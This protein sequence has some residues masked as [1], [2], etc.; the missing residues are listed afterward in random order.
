MDRLQIIQITETNA[1]NTYLMYIILAIAGYIIIKNYSNIYFKMTPNVPRFTLDVTYF[2][3]NAQNTEK[4]LQDYIRKITSKIVKEK[5]APVNDKLDNRNLLMKDLNDSVVKLDTKLK[6]QSEKKIFD[7][8]H[9]YLAMN[10][11]VTLLS[12]TL[13]Q[14]NNIQQ[15]NIEAVDKIYETYSIAM[16]EYLKKL[17]HVLTVINYQ[18]NITY[19]K[20][21]MQKMIKPLK[22][23]YNS[24]YNSL[25]NNSSFLQKF[26]PDYD[27][28][29][30]PKIGTKLDAPQDLSVKFTAS[31]PFMQSAGY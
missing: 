14:I 25:I 31:T 6:A 27:P 7:Y 26:I 9:S 18:I 10:N 21:S 30:V 23:L 13:G 1:T 5:A 24:I 16:K 17:L 3:S 11:S 19:I 28:S 12:N 8:Q 22:N 15:K 2:L 4:F 20:P 29:T